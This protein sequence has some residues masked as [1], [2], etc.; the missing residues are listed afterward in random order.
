MAAMGGGPSGAEIRDSGPHAQK[1]AAAAQC[2]PC[3]IRRRRR[4]ERH[5]IT[6]DNIHTHTH[7][8]CGKCAREYVTFC[9]LSSHASFP[10]T[11]AHMTK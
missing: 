4:S 11:R 10:H 9:A 2:V 1:A 5:A 7:T 3:A 6:I 8:R